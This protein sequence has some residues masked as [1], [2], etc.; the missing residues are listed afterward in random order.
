MKKRTTEPT[1]DPVLQKIRAGGLKFGGYLERAGVGDEA[2]LSRRALELLEKVAP[3]TLEA[4]PVAPVGSKLFAPIVKEIGLSSILS[5]EGQKQVLAWQT[6][7]ASLSAHLNQLGDD[8]AHQRYLEGMNQFAAGKIAEAPSKAHLL[9][10]FGAQRTAL[11]EKR[12][13][14]C[15]ESE[16]FCC[17]ATLRFSKI[18][19]T[20]AAAREAEERETWTQ[21]FGE[22]VPFEASPLLR[23]LLRAGKVL[24]GR[25][26]PQ[27]NA[28]EPRDQLY[29]SGLWA[30]KG[31]IK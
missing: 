26:Q 6:E 21:Q 24:V 25:A 19:A 11:R 28:M 31:K 10:S 15:K 18:V 8:A 5:E 3:Q 27:E 7:I 17:E 23:S 13:R 20:V 30:E 2:Q 1:D 22:D 29:W 12:K 4:E 9:A 14:V 16:S